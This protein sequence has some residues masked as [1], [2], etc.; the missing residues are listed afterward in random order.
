[1]AL[2][3]CLINSKAVKLCFEMYLMVNLKHRNR[4]H[5]TDLTLTEKVQVAFLRPTPGLC[6]QSEALLH[7]CGVVHSLSLVYSGL[8]SCTPSQGRKISAHLVKRSAGS[9]DVLL[10]AFAAAER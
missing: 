1:M 3:K 10:S 9:S 2:L 6:H 4:G 7:F 8:P 5:Q